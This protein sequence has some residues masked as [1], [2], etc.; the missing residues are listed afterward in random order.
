MRLRFE[1]GSRIDARTLV[2]VVEVHGIEADNC[3]LFLDDF[4]REVAPPLKHLVGLEGHK[5]APDAV[6]FIARS[7][8]R[9]RQARL[10]CVRGEF[11]SDAVRA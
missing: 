6:C 8:E 3:E 10:D 2:R 7:T 1:P 11:G 5:L 9:G 4:H